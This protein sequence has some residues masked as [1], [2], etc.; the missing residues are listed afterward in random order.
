[1]ATEESRFNENP[2]SLTLDIDYSEE[3]YEKFDALI[4]DAIWSSDAKETEGA[5]IFLGTITY[6]P[7]FEG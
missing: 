4:G 1:M 3:T 6:W 2:F 5:P 7:P